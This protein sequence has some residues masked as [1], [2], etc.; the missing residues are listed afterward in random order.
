MTPLCQRLMK[1]LR[2][3]T[4]FFQ[5]LSAIRVS[6]NGLASWMTNLT[7]EREAPPNSEEIVNQNLALS[8]M[9]LS[10]PKVHLGSSWLALGVVPT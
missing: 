2:M 4:A 7:F 9:D 5:S 8:L 1:N 3:S 10:H 6:T